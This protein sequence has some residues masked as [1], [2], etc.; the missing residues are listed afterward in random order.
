MRI[1][2]EEELSLGQEFACRRNSLEAREAETASWGE[3]R[4]ETRDRTD[5]LSHRDP[6]FFPA[7]ARGTSQGREG[8]PPAVMGTVRPGEG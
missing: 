2:A 7:G 8:I 4:D 3:G 5:H 1:Q 6:G